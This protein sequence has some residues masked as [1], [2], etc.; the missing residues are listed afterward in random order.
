MLNLTIALPT[1]NEERIEDSGFRSEDSE[2][3]NRKL[4][5]GFR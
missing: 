5:C 4:G 1:K 2:G 3:E